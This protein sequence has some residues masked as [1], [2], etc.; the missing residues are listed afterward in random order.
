MSL[1]NTLLSTV[2]LVGGVLGASGLRSPLPVRAD[3]QVPYSLPGMM[4]AAA[5][6]VSAAVAAQYC[7]QYT[8]QPVD[9]RM[10]LDSGG[11]E[12]VRRDAGS[13]LGLVQIYGYDQQ[14]HQTDWLAVLSNFHPLAHGRMSVE[15]FDESGQDLY[16]SLVVAR[17]AHGDLAGELTLDGQPYAVRWHRTTSR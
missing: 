10:R 15:L 4:P 12:I 11:I 3:G 5:Y 16:D 6:H 8:L 14:G 17:T 13:L 7:G 9:R 2:L 1:R